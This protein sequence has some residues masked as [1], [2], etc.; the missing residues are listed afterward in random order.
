MRIHDGPHARAAIR[1]ED[2]RS[3]RSFNLTQSGPVV[4]I[5]MLS[6]KAQFALD[7]PADVHIEIPSVLEELRLDNSVRVIVLTGTGDREFLVTPPV[8]YYRS[9]RAMARL[10]DPYG[11]WNVSN[12]VTRCFQI[13]TEIEKPII[14]RVN[15]DAIGF[16]QSM[17][18]G[19]DLIVAREDAL[20]S[21]VHLGMGEVVSRDGTH[22]GLPF[23]TVPGDGAGALIPLY[24]TPTKA[25]EYMMLSQTYT[26]A[27]LA[28]MNIVN[29]AVPAAELDAATDEIVSRLLKRSAFAL[30]WT[31][32]VLNRHVAH[33]T[34]LALDAAMAYEA[35]NFSQIQRLG[36]NADPT[37]LDRP[38]KGDSK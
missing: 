3:Y 19:C 12:G 35:L 33:Q 13:M 17:M 8:D 24:M 37:S 1:G 15:G 11:M 34:N 5:Q 7:P 32:R 28:K 16:G 29:R 26:A 30:A 27:E 10:G 14:A 18:L 31:K 6:L 20:I 25:K 2:M 38:N 21:D 22:V 23:G 36:V 4:T 9:D